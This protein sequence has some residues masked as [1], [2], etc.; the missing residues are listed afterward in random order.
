M[1]AQR[2]VQMG[3]DFFAEDFGVE[4]EDSEVSELADV[5]GQEDFIYV[6]FDLGGQVFFCVL[7]VGALGVAVLEENEGADRSQSFESIPDLPH[8]IL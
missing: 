8:Q 1:P 2:C 5:G 7:L 6:R 4:G 3:C